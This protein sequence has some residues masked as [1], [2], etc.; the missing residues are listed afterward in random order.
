M[1]YP[2]YTQP[3]PPPK[4]RR[5]TWFL[6]GLIIGA[7]SVGALA[8]SDDASEDRPVSTASQQ[9]STPTPDET[10]ASTSQRSVGDTDTTSGLA[11]TLVG[12]LDPYTSTNPF[13]VPGE[14]NRH[15]AV[16][17]SIQNTTDQRQTFS[18]ILGLELV[19]DLGRGWNIAFAGVDLPGIDF[20]LEP[21]E[22]RRGWAVFD[23]PI[24]ARGLTLI[25]KGSLTASGTRFAL[26]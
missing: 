1:N 11:V 16:E 19:D 7:G 20:D 24:D 23:I 2:T 18:S 14:G 13:D 26:I 25:V 21:G 9:P 17:L 8:T 5:W 10:T 4:R 6:L 3:A 22:I 12:F 15:V